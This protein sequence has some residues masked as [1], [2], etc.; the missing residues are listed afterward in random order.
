VCIAID[1]GRE[2]GGYL[3]GCAAHLVLVAARVWALVILGF[4]SRGTVSGISAVVLVIIVLVLRELVGVPSIG[5]SVVGIQTLAAAAVGFL[6]P[7]P[8]VVLLWFTMWESRGVFFFFWFR[9]CYCRDCLII[10]ACLMLSPCPMSV[11]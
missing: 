1:G 8:I 9:R 3:L 2:G 7:L 11:V 10:L 4:V 5:V 6:A